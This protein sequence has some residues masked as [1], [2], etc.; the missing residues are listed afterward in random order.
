MTTVTVKDLR[1]LKYCSQG[2][3]QFFAR[4]E[5]D[6]ATFVREGLPEEAFAN[7]DDAMLTRIIEQARRREAVTNE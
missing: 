7:V 3:R 4:H 1:A 6:W 2:S 5:L